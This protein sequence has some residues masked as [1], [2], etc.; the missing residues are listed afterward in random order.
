MRSAAISRMPSESSDAV[1]L[2]I[3]LLVRY[4]ELATIVS[5]PTDGTLTL[6]FAIGAPLGRAAVR[7]TREAVA[8]H[9]RSLLGLTGETPDALTVESESDG[10][11]TF[12]RVTRDARSFSREELQLL[13]AVL[14]QRFGDKL[15]RSPAAED[16]GYDDEGAAD[17]LVDYAVEALRDPESQRSLVGFREE[18]RVLVYFVKSRKK[19]KARAR[20]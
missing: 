3:A 20:S 4:P 18:K 8:E 2:I 1:G 14:T 19:A 11:T 5:H 16:D 6:S 7:D 9:V 10:G 12:F 15:Y 17:E 13:V